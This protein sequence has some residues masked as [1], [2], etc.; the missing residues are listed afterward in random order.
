MGRSGMK[1]HR[2][3]F[4]MGA[5][6]GFGLEITMAALSTGARVVST[7]RKNP[8]QLI[9]SLGNHPHLQ[10]VVMDVTEESAVKEAVKTAIVRF[11]RI[12]VLLNGFMGFMGAIEEATN[13]EVKQ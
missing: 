1:Q 13:A 6:F 12:D 5:S 10:V 4:I 7:V 2:V 8:E 11:E 9:E 3:W